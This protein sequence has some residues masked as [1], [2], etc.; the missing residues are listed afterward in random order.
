MIRKHR[1]VLALVVLCSGA[2]ANLKKDTSRVVTGAAIGAAGMAA[3]Q[4]V[5]N[6]GKMLI[7][8]GA[9][10]SNNFPGLNYQMVRVSA[11]FGAATGLLQTTYLRTLRAHWTMASVKSNQRLIDL[12][13]NEYENDAAL[14][15]AL[16]RYCIGYTYPLVIAHRELAYLLEC[17]NDAAWLIESALADIDQDSLRAEDLNDWLD[18]I[19]TMRTH[20]AYAVGAIDKDPRILTLIDA[21]NRI[22]QTNALWADAIAHVAIAASNVML[23]RAE[24]PPIVSN[25]TINFVNQ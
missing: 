5:L 10:D 23:A 21:Q 12:T 18:E 1:V 6:A 19:Y 17:L 2:H 11:A 7:W 25:S 9:W 15:A 3:A 22:D 4:A 24:A 8:D 13:M 14:I 16:E 20:V